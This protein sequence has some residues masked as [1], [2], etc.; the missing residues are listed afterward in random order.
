MSKLAIEMYL[1]GKIDNESFLMIP[2][3]DEDIDRLLLKT[4]QSLIRKGKAIDAVSIIHESKN[5][6]VLGLYIEIDLEIL[7][8]QRLKESAKEAL[9]MEKFVVPETASQK[10]ARM[11]ATKRFLEAKDP[12][13]KELAYKLWKAEYESR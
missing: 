1:E 3:N 8:R 11:I 5:Q 12:E 2:S 9:D 7:K 10:E 6:K 13:E 4:M